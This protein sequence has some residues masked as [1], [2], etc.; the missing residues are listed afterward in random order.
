MQLREF[1][2]PIKG[3]EWI[4]KFRRHEFWIGAKRSYPQKVYARITKSYIGWWC[5]FRVHAIWHRAALL[6]DPL[7]CGGLWSHVNT[8]LFNAVVVDVWWTLKRKIWK[9]RH[10]EEWKRQRLFMRAA[11]QAHSEGCADEMPTPAGFEGKFSGAI[12]GRRYFERVAQIIKEEESNH[13]A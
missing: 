7:S 2:R 9:L 4:E 11:I 1:L 13:E 5:Y 6:I 10:P 12:L 3:E 8:F